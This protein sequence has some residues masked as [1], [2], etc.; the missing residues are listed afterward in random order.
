MARAV[1]FKPLL[2][3]SSQWRPVFYFYFLKKIEEIEI[4]GF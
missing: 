2:L 1:A 3:M 4:K